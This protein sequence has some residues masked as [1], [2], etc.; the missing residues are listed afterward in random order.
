MRTSL[1]VLVAFAV[2]ATPLYADVIPSKRAQGAADQARV[3]DRVSS[4]GG[5][6]AQAKASAADLTSKDGAFFASHP[7]RVQVVGAQQDMFSGE[8]NNLWFETILGA[9]WL[10]AGVG[11]IAYMLT[12]NE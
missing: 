5:D 9:G 7:E 11:I 4:L 12:N 6:T 3:G 8:S 1:V 2:F 10:V